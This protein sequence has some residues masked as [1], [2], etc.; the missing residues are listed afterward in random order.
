[1]TSDDREHVTEGSGV[2][3]IPRCLSDRNVPIRVQRQPKECREAV[4]AKEQRRR[5]FDGSIRP[6]ALG[7]DA[8]MSTTFLKGDFQTPALHK[9]ADDLFCRL[10]GV[11]GK[12]GFG[13][14]F[15]LR[16]TS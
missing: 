10:G 6:L 4:A 7:L 5:A 3:A 13:R 16:I 1:M 11:G 12:D 2:L 15:S 14:A 8:Q 9:I